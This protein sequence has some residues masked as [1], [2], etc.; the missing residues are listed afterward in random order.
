MS[1]TEMTRTRLQ[2]AQDCDRELVELISANLEK[3]VRIGVLLDRMRGPNPHRGGLFSELGYKS[4]EAYVKDRFDWSYRHAVRQ[5]EASQLR[6]RIPDL[7]LSEPDHGGQDPA[8]VWT[9]SNMR[10]LGRL[11]SP[12]KA[13]AVAEKVVKD[14]KDKRE[15]GEKVKLGSIVRKR[16]QEALGPMPKPAPREEPGFAVVVRGWLEEVKGMVGIL[17]TLSEDE[18]KLF[19]RDES[20]L[21][22]DFAAAVGKLAQAWE[23]TGRPAGRRAKVNGG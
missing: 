14:V 16:V 2:E 11:Q 15:K 10:D 5:I 19:G 22:K 4:F 7:P 1:P 6:L 18:L 8:P 21:A 17:Q 3:F 20:Y 12:T 23:V 13:K 9:E